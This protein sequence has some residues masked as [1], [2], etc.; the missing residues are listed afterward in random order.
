MML[1]LFIIMIVLI[2]HVKILFGLRIQLF[3]TMLH[4]DEISLHPTLLLTLVKLEWEIKGW[5]VL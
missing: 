4:L 5:L 2:L 3:L 1:P